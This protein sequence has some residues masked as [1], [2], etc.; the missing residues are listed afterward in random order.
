MSAKQWIELRRAGAARREHGVETGLG[1]A[2][3]DEHEVG[4]RAHDPGSGSPRRG[5]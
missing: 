3:A 5:P 1:D 2:D 4:R